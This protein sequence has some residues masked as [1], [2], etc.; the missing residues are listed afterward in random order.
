MKKLNLLILVFATIFIACNKDDDAS[1]EE[2]S[3]N[4]ELIVGK[5]DVT[6]II[7]DGITLDADD[8]ELNSTIHIKEDGTYEEQIYG[9]F[10]GSCMP[11]DL[12]KGTWELSENI[13]TLTLDELGNAIRLTFNHTILELTETTLKYEFEDEDILD[14]GTVD[15]FKEVWTFTRMK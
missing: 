8:C 5:W 11:D 7:V 9:G 3:S 10:V 6:S 4:K 2:T 13:L 15:P 1:N 12:D 14:D